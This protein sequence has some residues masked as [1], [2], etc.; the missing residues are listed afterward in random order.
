MLGV[1]CLKMPIVALAT[2]LSAVVPAE[3]HR[4]ERN[5]FQKLMLFYGL[6]R[7]VFTLRHYNWKNAEIPSMKI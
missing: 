2:N 3:Q 4:T 5:V 6:S 1:S 7:T